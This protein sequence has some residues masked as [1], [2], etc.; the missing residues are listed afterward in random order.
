MADTKVS[1]LTELTVG[2]ADADE[3]YINDGGTSKKITAANLLNPE[4]LT[5]L[6]AAP[7][8]TD[9]I[10]INDGG[11]GK[12]I[13]VANLMDFVAT[14]TAKGTVEL[15][16]T[17]EIEAGTDAARCM[18]I[19]QFVASDRN[20]RF[21]EIRLVADGTDVTTGAKGGDFRVPF[22]GTIIQDDNNKHYFCAYNDTAGTTGTMV[23]DVHLN[24][25]TIMTTNK[26]DIETGE[27]T[28]A[29]ATTQPDV[30]TTAVTAGDILTF[31]IDAIHTTAAKG[32]VVRIPIR[33]T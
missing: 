17:A 3:V 29:D 28:T 33:L 26:L 15:A 22:T 27:K 23:V 11:V 5:E 7:A 2:P 4:N 19:D 30:T 21:I 8:S 32:L 13:S 25:T 16:T 1:A 12:K 18:P 24:G 6:S 9:E 14:L 10:A 20:I 31:I